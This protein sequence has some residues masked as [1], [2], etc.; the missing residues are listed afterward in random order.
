MVTFVEPCKEVV[1]AVGM[2]ARDIVEVSLMKQIDFE[3]R[4]ESGSRASMS[5]S[6]MKLSF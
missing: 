1:D 6:Q 4:Q 2:L 3:Y 5:Y